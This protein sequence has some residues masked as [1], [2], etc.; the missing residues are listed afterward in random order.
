[1]NDNLTPAARDFLD[2][3]RDA[4]LIAVTEGKHNDVEYVGKLFRDMYDKELL[5]SK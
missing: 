3:A 1:M 4:F 5:A 2:I